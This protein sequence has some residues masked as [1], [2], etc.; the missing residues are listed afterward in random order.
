MVTRRDY[1]LDLLDDAARDPSVNLELMFKDLFTD[2]DARIVDVEDR[3][4]VFER[5]KDTIF[6]ATLQ[7][8]AEKLEPEFERIRDLGDLGTLFE[9]HSSTELEISIGQKTVIVDEADRP[10][11]TPA[12]FIGLLRANDPGNAM[13]GG[14]ASY[15]RDTGILVVNVDRIVGSGTFSDWQVVAT[16]ATDYAAAAVDAQEYRD[17]AAQ[18]FADT[19]AARDAAQAYRDTAQT[20]ATTATGAQAAAVA[21]QAAAEI[22][23][24]AAESHVAG[25]DELSKRYNGPA[26]AD[27]TTRPDLT[28]L[29][30]GD[31]YWNSVANEMRIYD[32]AAW[33]VAYVPSG[34]DVTSWNSRI[35]AVMPQAGDYT[36]AQVT[37]TPA[38]N[39]AATTVQA[40][41]NE[42]DTEKAA[43]GHVHAASAITNT[44]AGGIAATNVQTA[45]NELD[46]EKAPKADPEFSGTVKAG[47]MAEISGAAGTNRALRWL[48]GLLRRFSVGINADA[49]AGSNA[50]SNFYLS[51][52]ADDGS[53]SV[54]VI[55][56]NRATGQI[57]LEASDASAAKLVLPHGVDPTAHVNGGIWTKTDG[58]YFRLNGA[59]YKAS[60]DGHTHAV[61][62]QGA[63]GFMSNV[64]K[65]KLD[66]IQ[67]GATAYSHPTGDGSLHV[68]ATS[69][70]NNLKVLKA[71]ASPGSAA[72]GFV[73]YGELTGIPT[74]ISILG[75]LTPAADRFPYYTGAGT[76]V[77]GTI[78]AA[79]RALLDDADA[80]TQR[81]TMGAAAA[82]HTHAVSD[83]TG[84]QTQLDVK[85][86]A[87]QPLLDMPRFS[88]P[89]NVTGT[90][91]NALTLAG[92]YDGDAMTN[93]PSAGWWHVL[94]M[95]HSGNDLWVQQIAWALTVDG[96]DTM[97]LR[98]RL[99]GVWGAWKR[100]ANETDV[101][102]KAPIA[103]PSFTGSMALN[104]QAVA[105]QGGTP[106]FGNAYTNAWWRVNGNG[107]IYW[108][109]WGGGFYMDAA[110]TIKTYAGVG[111]TAGAG[112][113]S[114]LTSN[115]GT[116]PHSG[117]NADTIGQFGFMNFSG[118]A[119]NKND[120]TAG[121]NLTWANHTGSG[122][123][124]SPSGTWKC[125]GT[126]S[127]SNQAT[128]WQR[129]A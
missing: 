67:A 65:A 81:A 22:A 2:V 98:S 20:H 61:A 51:R 121:S 3:V 124:G 74:A 92:F 75:G 8:M 54:V 23:E 79:G 78:T 90:D 70:T 68:P 73:A 88:R 41:I 27:P 24:A 14:R 97:Y 26:A 106:T 94:V 47:L 95:R 101:S 93:A 71:G 72:W 87:S 4:L 80:A 9:A 128:L 18:F 118:S 42:L 112:V 34:S 17:E 37:N 35:G 126:M 45:L 105:V 5:L 30:E 103:N 89:Y 10:R 125:L 49:E 21:A 58:L 63:S 11:F 39:I 44:P 91:L 77:L 122:G 86:N 60:V 108:E 62:T 46:T 12:G 115:G 83:V 33:T 32:G 111:I 36:A 109:S 99:N 38:G 7:Y 114:S 28:A 116:V 69:T 43:T 76:A 110:G 1:Y 59:S 113:F 29:V 55:A 31:L 104:G 123:G 16:S 127:G 40:A 119:K 102:S 107:G 66:N 120:T 25:I 56:V 53:T 85:A 57:T 48:T 82:V 84:L 129:I 15:N 19:Q 6:D 13:A 64:D 117:M 50:G 100:M 52:F 96:S